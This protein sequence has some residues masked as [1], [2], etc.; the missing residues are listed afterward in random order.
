MASARSS[1]ALSATRTAVGVLREPFSSPWLTS[2]CTSRDTPI[3]IPTP[4]Y[5]VLPSDASESYR[6]PPPTDPNDSWPTS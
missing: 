6:P 2:R 1:S 3:E 5:V 4:G